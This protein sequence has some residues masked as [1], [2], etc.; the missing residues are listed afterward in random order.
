MPESVL[1]QMQNIESRMTAIV[2][3]ARMVSFVKPE[4]DDGTW[5]IHML[6]HN[7]LYILSAKQNSWQMYATFN[8]P[9]YCL[10]NLE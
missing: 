8:Y 7:E 6:R 2:K 10:L 4:R 1:L 9:L 3:Y 5:L